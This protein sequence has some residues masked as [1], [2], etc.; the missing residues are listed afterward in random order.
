MLKII[1]DKFTPSRIKSLKPHF[2][3]G[4]VAQGGKSGVA[5]QAAKTGDITNNA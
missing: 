4:L 2:P 1:L 3:S 5:G